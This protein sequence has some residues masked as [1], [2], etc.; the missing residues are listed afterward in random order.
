MKSYRHEKKRIQGTTKTIP[1]SSEALCGYPETIDIAVVT[2]SPGREKR[3]SVRTW[4]LVILSVTNRNRLALVL[5][6][7][8]RHGARQK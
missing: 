2:P 8:G 3:L 7:H 5:Q 4:I 1:G 6:T